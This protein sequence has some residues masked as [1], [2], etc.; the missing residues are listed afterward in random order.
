[1]HSALTRTIL[2]AA[3]LAGG[4]A[5]AQSNDPVAGGT[6]A[7]PAQALPAPAASAAASPRDPFW[8]VG[9]QPPPKVVATVKAEAPKEILHVE[10]VPVDLRAVVAEKT[11]INGIM[12]VGGQYLALINNDLVG[13]GE[14]IVIRH[15]GSSY[16]LIVRS[17]T[18]DNVN[19]E[20]EEKK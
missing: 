8:P 3:T 7:L 20:P 6:A 18:K 9:Y 14:K 5:A 16:T 15:A 19:L 2:L 13:V 4:S 12:K 1:M 11:Q 10:N 17:I